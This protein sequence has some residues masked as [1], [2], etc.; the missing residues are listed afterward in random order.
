MISTF[1]DGLE[2]RHRTG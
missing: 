2:V 1:R